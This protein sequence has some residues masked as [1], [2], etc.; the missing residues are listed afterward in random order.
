MSGSTPLPTHWTI[1]ER[2]SIA[3][4][5]FKAIS[6]NAYNLWVLIEG[7][8]MARQDHATFLAGLSYRTWGTLLLTAALALI[9]IV[10]WRRTTQV[11]LLWAALATTFSIFMLP[12]RLHERYLLPAVALAVLCAAILPRLRWPAILLSLTYF[13]NLFLVYRM[14][15]NPFGGAS[16][17]PPELIIRLISATNVVVWIAVAGGRHRPGR[18]QATKRPAGC[19]G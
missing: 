17:E 5:T 4:N 19:P 14:A 10:F 8:A 13:A 6:A 2:V 9:L 7:R 3:A 12:T 1:F 18:R 16:S 15:R 11:M